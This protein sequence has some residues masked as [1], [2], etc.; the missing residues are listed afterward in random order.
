MLVATA[1]E[2][3]LWFIFCDE[4]RDASMLARYRNVLLSRPAA[5]REATFHRHEDRHRYLLTRAGIRCILSQYVPIAPAEWTFVSDERGRPQL[6]DAPA[7]ARH[8]SFNI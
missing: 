1:A 2:I 3:H 6:S 5:E 7:E 4:A 8:L